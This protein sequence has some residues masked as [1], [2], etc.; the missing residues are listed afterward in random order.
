ARDPELALQLQRRDPRPVR[1]DQVGR[2]NPQRQRQT[3]LVHHRSR[4]HRRLPTAGLALPKMTT[5][6]NADRAA[7]ASRAG[8]PVRPPRR[9]Q[10]RTTPWLVWKEAL[11][12]D[13][14]ARKAGTRHPTTVGP[15]RTQL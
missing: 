1:C 5:M 13:Y 8:E 3:R 12:L 9:K 2:P 14:R 11:E 7:A 10:V 4:G 15:P 6:L